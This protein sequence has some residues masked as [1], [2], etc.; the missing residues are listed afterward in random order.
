[1]GLL[2][3]MLFIISVVADLG[4]LEKLIPAAVGAV[5]LGAVIGMLVEAVG[6]GALPR[7]EEAVAVSI[8]GT[9]LSLFIVLQLLSA[10]KWRFWALFL[11]ICSVCAAMALA[12]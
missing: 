2:S 4:V 1:M 10:S 6:H 9:V 11:P 7:A 5:G 3:V 8:A 12:Q